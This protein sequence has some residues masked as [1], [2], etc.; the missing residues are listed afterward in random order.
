VEEWLETARRTLGDGADTAW[1]EGEA[2][3]VPEAVAL[4]AGECELALSES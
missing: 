3:T 2:L 4:A 1:S